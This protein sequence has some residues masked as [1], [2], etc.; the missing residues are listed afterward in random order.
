MV[1]FFV[2]RDFV[3]EIIDKEYKLFGMHPKVKPAY[4]SPSEIARIHGKAWW[5]ALHRTYGRL[6]VVIIVDYSTSLAEPVPWARIIVVSELI[7]IFSEGAWKEKCP[8]VLLADP[9]ASQKLYEDLHWKAHK[10]LSD[11]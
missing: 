1:D 8:E 11:R 9:K 4:P 5:G 10:H 6:S 3:K 7:S 2:I